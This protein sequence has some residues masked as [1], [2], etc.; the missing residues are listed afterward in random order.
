MPFCKSCKVV[1]PE[2][3]FKKIKDNLAKTCNFCLTTRQN[4]YKPKKL[5]TKPLTNNS[6]NNIEEQANN[7]EIFLNINLN[8]KFEVFN[9][10]EI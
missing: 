7:N 4:N 10:M 3:S 1:L 2:E 6:I 5:S 8:I 9:M